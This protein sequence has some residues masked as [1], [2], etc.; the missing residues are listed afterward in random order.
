MNNFLIKSNAYDEYWL[1]AYHR[2]L[3]FKQRV[4]ALPSESTPDQVIKKYKFTNCYRALDRTTQH[5]LKEITNAPD[6]TAENVF[7]QTILFKIFNNQRTWSR[8]TDCIGAI[9]YRD[10]KPDAYSSVLK[11][12]KNLGD[13]IYSAAYI[14]PSGKKEFGSAIKH[15]NNMRMLELMLKNELHKKIWDM[16]NLRGIYDTF[17][18]IPTI[19][20]F[21]AYQ[22]SIDIAYSQYSAASEDQYV[23]AGPGA[24]RGINKC[25]SNT[26]GKSHSYIIQH[27]MESQEREFSRLGLTFPFLANRKLQLID[28]QN[29]FCEVDKYLRVKRPELNQKSARIKQNY[30]IT[31]D[32]IKYTFPVKWGGVSI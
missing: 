18:K 31:P 10:F 17:I 4:C 5:L 29:I 26:A 24:I 22:Y 28:C 19:G 32:E 16:K 15:E 8:L 11:S 14:M 20:P 3:V 7:F 27:M 6:L 25:F 21:L 9:D 30:K 2:Q 1:F 23:V 13:P 12:I